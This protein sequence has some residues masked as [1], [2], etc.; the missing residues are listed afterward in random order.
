MTSVTAHLFR[1][2]SRRLIKRNGLTSDQLVRHL[3][4]QFNHPPGLTLLPRGI[5]HHRI[6]TDGFRGDVIAVAN[7]QRAILYFHGGAYMAGTPRTYHN[8]AGRLAKALNAAV[9]LPVYPFAPEHPFP[10]AVNSCL[11]AYRWLLD[12][13]YDPAKIAIGGDSAGGGLTL[14]T[15]LNIKQEGLAKPAC[16]FTFS[17]ATDSREQP[18][19]AA[20]DERDAMLSA[21]MIRTAS[22]VYL[23]NPADRGL[24]LAS[25][26]LG[27]YSGLGPLMITVDRTECLYDHA[28]ALRAKTQADGVLVEWLERD[29]LLHVWPTL[30]PWLPEAR[31][32]LKRVAAFLKRWL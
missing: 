32:D 19:V 29:G 10:A 3:R 23:P 8:M 13:G 24:P 1:Q 27:D 12:E 6:D 20:N 5:R 11:Q 25:P 15:L 28:T 9:Y 14:S 26:C 30:V 16:A 7:P 31:R 4:K 18:S 2:V 21:D 22:E 17:P